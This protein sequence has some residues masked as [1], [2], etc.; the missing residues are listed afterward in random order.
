MT[1]L[2]VGDD[3]KYRDI[4]QRRRVVREEIAMCAQ[5]WL[6]G[7]NAHLIAPTLAIII[8]GGG[9]TSPQ[10]CTLDYGTSGNN[11]QIFIELPNCQSTSSS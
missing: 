10:V 8:V 1:P 5:N 7:E 4:E 3:D 11:F 9:S 2:D 6:H